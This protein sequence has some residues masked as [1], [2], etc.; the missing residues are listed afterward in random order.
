MMRLPETDIE[1]KNMLIRAGKVAVM[2]FCVQTGIIPPTVSQ[3]AAERECG[4]REVRNWI[5]KRIISRKKEGMGNHKIEIDRVELE[6]TALA[7]NRE[8]FITEK[9]DETK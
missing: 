6:A 4:Q 2:E 8:Y 7:S 9:Q 3:R 1:L 5:R